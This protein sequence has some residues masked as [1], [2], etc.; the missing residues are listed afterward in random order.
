MNER[1]LPRSVPAL[2]ADMGAGST[3][4]FGNF[5]EQIECN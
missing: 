5:T 4:Y 2:N 3:A 1:L